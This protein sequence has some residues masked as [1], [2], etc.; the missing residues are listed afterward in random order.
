MHPP[1]P[2]ILF[3]FDMPRGLDCASEKLLIENNKKVKKRKYTGAMP[4][5][6]KHYLT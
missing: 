1:S 6:K 3:I 4:F 2:I 5:L